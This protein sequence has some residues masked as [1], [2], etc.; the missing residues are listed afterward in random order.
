MQ[1]FFTYCKE[2]KYIFENNYMNFSSLNTE[3]GL[4]LSPGH[5]TGLFLQSV[6]KCG[7]ISVPWKH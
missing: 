2:Q 4:R 3:L 1:F 5:T 7:T 6:K